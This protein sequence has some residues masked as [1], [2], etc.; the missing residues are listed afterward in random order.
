MAS[1][2]WAATTVR[3]ICKTAGLNT[4]YFYECFDGL[5]ELLV[6]VFDWIIEDSIATAGSAMAAA[7]KDSRSQVHAGVVGAV[8]ALTPGAPVS[9]PPKRWAA[10]GSPVAACG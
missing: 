7:D 10:S 2:G 6:A 4:R 1:S 9:S 3:E 5:D 8:T